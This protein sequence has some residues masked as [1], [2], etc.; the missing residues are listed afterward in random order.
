MKR[1]KTSRH[2]HT[3]PLSWLKRSTERHLR[4]VGVVVVVVVVV[5]GG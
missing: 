3:V 5:G 2:N 4:S 1:E